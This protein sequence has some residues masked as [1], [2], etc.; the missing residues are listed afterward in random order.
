MKMRQLPSDKYNVAW[1]KLAEF[2]VRGERERALGLY[3]LLAHSFDRALAYQLEG[4]ILLS[5]KDK[6]G[7][8]QKYRNAA[9]LYKNDV[10]IIEAAALYEHLITLDSQCQENL[11]QVIQLYE[12]L[13]IGSRLVTHLE[14]LCCLF[15]GNEEFEQLEFLMNEWEKK[16]DYHHSSHLY[17]TITLELIKKKTA[18]EIVCFYL[19]KTIDFLLT[20]KN[21]PVLQTF[22]STI[23]ALHEDYYYEATIHMQEL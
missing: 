13:G 21:S 9:E 14:H 4:D 17:K 5:F 19:K 12:I 20:N 3:K 16:I 2:V 7:A 22:L 18:R 10:R 11:I 1:F 6:V 23:E 8:C 15:I